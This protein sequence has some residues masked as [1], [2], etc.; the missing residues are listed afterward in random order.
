MH[1]EHLPLVCLP[2]EL[3]DDDAAKLLEFLHELARVL[4]STYA[5]QL[6]RHYTAAMTANPTSGTTTIPPSDRRRHRTRS[7]NPPSLRHR[8]TLNHRSAQCGKSMPTHHKITR[9]ISGET[10]KETTTAVRR[11]GC[12]FPECR[13]N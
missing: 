13:T 4:E 7:L 10:I 1:T 5:A 2:T 12:H 8:P 6:H 9:E 3:C 11:L